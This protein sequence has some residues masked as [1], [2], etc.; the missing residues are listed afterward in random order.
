MPDFNLTPP[1]RSYSVTLP[2]GVS[3]FP[4]GEAKG[5][6]IPTGQALGLL[7]VFMGLGRGADLF[8]IGDG[9]FI[10]APAGWRDTTFDNQS[11]AP[12]N[13]F[14]YVLIKDAEAYVMG[15]SAV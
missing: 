5:I 12:I 15:G 3:V 10:K 4:A 11:G 6:W 8:P 2:I 7:S 13:P 14:R 9:V 1:F